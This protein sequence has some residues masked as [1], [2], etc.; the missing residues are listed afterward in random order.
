MKKV[1]E[2][3]KY[4]K[5]GIKAH[6]VVEGETIE[7][8]F[9]R[10]LEN[11][12]PVKDGAPLLYTERKDGV[13]AEF[14]IRTDRFEIAVEATDKIQKSYKAKREGKNL[15]LQVDKPEGQSTQGTDTVN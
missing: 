12:E 7:M 9:K 5:S 8:K 13:K 10:I 15:A 14:N 11:K 2:K 4:L 6:E 3:P 1:F